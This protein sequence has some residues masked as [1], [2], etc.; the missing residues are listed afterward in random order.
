MST[1]NKLTSPYLLLLG[2]II[3]AAFILSYNNASKKLDVDQFDVKKLS[4]ETIVIPYLKEHHK[5]PDYYI[6]KKKAR[7][8]GWNANEGNLCDKLPGKVI[9][10]DVFFNRENSLPNKNGRKWFEAD[11]NYNCGHRGKDRLIFS[12]DGLIFVTYNHYKTFEPK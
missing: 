9:G 1:K 7:Q 6:T 4:S 8:M 2:V 11:L 3:I 12:N 10:G 5:L